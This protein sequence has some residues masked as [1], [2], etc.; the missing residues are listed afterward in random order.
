MPWGRKAPGH[1]SY[2]RLNGLFG[3]QHLIDSTAMTLYKLGGAIQATERQPS[4]APLIANAVEAHS[5]MLQ[6][7][8]DRAH[9]K[10]LAAKLNNVVLDQSSVEVLREMSDALTRDDR[11]LS[12]DERT[13]LLRIAHLFERFSWLLSHLPLQEFARIDDA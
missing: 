1:V 10:S 4:L 12:E 13:K 8:I 7:A 2:D 5:R 6:A 9:S 3:H 11:Q